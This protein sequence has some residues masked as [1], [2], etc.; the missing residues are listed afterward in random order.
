MKNF[1]EVTSEKI[2]ISLRLDIAKI[3]TAHIYTI[4]S[5]NK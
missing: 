1:L 5:V 4:E 2:L 3:K